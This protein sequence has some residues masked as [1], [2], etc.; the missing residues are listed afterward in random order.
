MVIEF[1]STHIN[2]VKV[3]K[4]LKRTL[5]LFILSKI[6]FGNKNHIVYTVLETE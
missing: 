6:Y 1:Q 4:I 3:I 5:I 2:N